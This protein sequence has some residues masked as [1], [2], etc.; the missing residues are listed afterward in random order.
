MPPETS[1]P[2][3]ETG[4]FKKWVHAECLVRALNLR[5]IVTAIAIST[6]SPGHLPFELSASRH[7]QLQT[8]WGQSRL[9]G[10][11]QVC[12]RKDYSLY[13]SPH[14][15]VD[16]VLD[17]E[18]VLFGGE[19]APVLPRATLCTLSS[20]PCPLGSCQPRPSVPRSPTARGRPSTSRRPSFAVRGTQ[21]SRWAL[22]LVSCAACPSPVTRRPSQHL[23]HAGLCRRLENTWPD[24]VESPL[25]AGRLR[26]P[27]QAGEGRGKRPSTA[28][29]L[30]SPIAFLPL[31][32]TH[33]I[34]TRLSPPSGQNIVF[35]LQRAVPQPLGSLP[36]AG[37]GM[38]HATHV[39][40]I[41]SA[42]RAGRG[43]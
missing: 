35:C 4:G 32:T 42:E 43:Q 40:V 11:A 1:L 27:R 25:S 22:Q 23:P 12:Y 38:L 28:P 21:V 18:L 37:T 7:M 10:E 3:C 17:T 16:R 36:V 5:A 26:H 19:R 34:L 6:A 13:R 29:V 2:F 9:L 8:K 24:G 41:R 14:Y 33:T 15:W 20:C 39:G 31:P 30:G